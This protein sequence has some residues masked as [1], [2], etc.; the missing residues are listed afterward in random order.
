MNSQQ[1]AKSSGVLLTTHT[2]DVLKAVRALQAKL[3][4]E[5]P[6]EWWLALRYAALLHDLGKLDPAFQER[7]KKR[8]RR[9]EGTEAETNAVSVGDIPHSIFSLFFI[10]PERFNFN[11]SYL[12]HVIISAV[13]FHHW[14][15]NFPDYL[16]G[17]KEFRIKEKA[18]E[19]D[20]KATEWLQL[21]K[22]LIEELSL[23][24]EEHELD[25]AVMGLNRTLVEYLRY[26][27]LG[28]AGVLIPPY[29]LVYLPEQIR[30]KAVTEEEID[31][32]RIFIAG[33][34]MR[35]DHFA[36]MVEESGMG[37]D[38]QAIESGRVLTGEEIEGFLNE[39]FKQ[40]DYWQKAFF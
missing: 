3:P 30:A 26:N 7:I 1:W 20:E 35:A 24:A 21:S 11:V 22:G 9:E 33:S 8:G 40:R 18:A 29:T 31:R 13:V 17:N 39:K 4:I 5:V 32:A 19:L 27:S 10:K 12:A 36:S 16:L 38:I 15:D 37:L 2:E 23:L 25:P 34:L 6:K 28:S 14:R